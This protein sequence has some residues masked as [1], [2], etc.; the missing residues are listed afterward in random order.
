MKHVKINLSRII[1]L[2]NSFNRDR[3]ILHNVELGSTSIN[4]MYANE[5]P[6]CHYGID[7]DLQFTHGYHDMC[8][9]EEDEFNLFT[10]HFCPHCNNGFVVEH[11]MECDEFGYSEA[12][13]VVYP[14]SHSK[15]YI[16]N[17]IK[18]ISP[19][20]CKI[21]MQSLTAK[22]TGLTEI[23]GMGFRKAIEHLVK[24]YAIYRKPNEAEQIKNKSLHDCIETYFDESDAKTALL[25]AKWLG[26][27]ETHY[28]NYNDENDLKYFEIIISDIMHY[29]E[30]KLRLE[31]AEEINAK[32]GKK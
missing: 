25:G 29:I 12:S 31:R 11:R 2:D 13:Q 6:R 30:R 1:A 3:N 9:L 19:A 17:E 32:K 15:P 20:F 23:Y 27:N 26:N 22:G 28:V 8:S 4:I 14:Y 5:C 18:Q 24:D 10:I 21:Y 7:M 16:S